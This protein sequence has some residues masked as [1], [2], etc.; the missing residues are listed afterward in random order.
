MSEK[1]WKYLC[2][3]EQKKNKE[4][5]DAMLQI[6]I[7]NGRHKDNDIDWICKQALEGE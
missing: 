5:L 6:K 7:L 2:K 1:Y 4:L 3:K